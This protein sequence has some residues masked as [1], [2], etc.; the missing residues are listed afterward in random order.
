MERW[1]WHCCRDAICPYR[2]STQYGRPEEVGCN[3]PGDPSVHDCELPSAEK[4]FTVARGALRAGPCATFAIFPID[5]LMLISERR[6]GPVSVPAAEDERSDGE[7]GDES[8]AG[9]GDE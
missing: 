3:T 2:P 8:G 6:R 5:E 1:G 4:R 7:D 9:A